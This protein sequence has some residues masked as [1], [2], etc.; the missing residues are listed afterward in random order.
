MRRLFLASFVAYSIDKFIEA[1]ELNPRSLT[2]AFIPTAANVYPPEKRGF[3][4]EDR[5]ALTEKGFKVKDIGIAGKQ[6]G[7]LTAELKGA[8]II[9]VSGG[10][11]F[12]LLQATRES[13]FNELTKQLVGKGVIYAG[14]SA[15]A[16]LAGPDIEPV[17]PLDDH[18]KNLNLKST[19]GLGLVDFV[20]LPHWGIEKYKDQYREVMKNYGKGQYKLIKITDEQAVV[21]EG[22]KHKIV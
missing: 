7:E 8:D 10:S 14:S 2:V 5:G 1:F 3:V 13:G 15:G 4:K 19:K 22:N 18:S 11:P 20:V 12:Y 9:F 17:R 6:K 16:V 21:V